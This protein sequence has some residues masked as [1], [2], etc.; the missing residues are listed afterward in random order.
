M[1]KLAALVPTIVGLFV[2][3]ISIYAT[4]HPQIRSKPLYWV[5]GMSAAIV[6]HGVW[7]YMAQRMGDQQDIFLYALVWDVG[8][9][10]LSVAVPAVLF[11]L[12]IGPAG[13][14]GVALIV[15]GGLLLKLNFS[16]IGPT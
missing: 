16:S 10:L 7:T 11:K 2:Y 6:G 15:A 14:A 3:A 9:T 5:I 13:Y 12:P 4:Y 1:L 8:F